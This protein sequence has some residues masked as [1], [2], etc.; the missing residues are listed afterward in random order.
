MTPPTN[1]TAEG[2]GGAIY[3]NSATA[4]YLT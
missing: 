3:T 2:Y 4:P 1:N